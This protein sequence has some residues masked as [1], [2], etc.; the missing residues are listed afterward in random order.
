MLRR[1]LLTAAAA[2][3]LIIAT[4]IAG[5]VWYDAILALVLFSAVVE[6]LLAAGEQ[7]RDP[8][9]WLAAVAAGGF[10]LSAR[11]GLQWPAALLAGF[12]LVSLTWLVLSERLD[13]GAR[14]WLLSTG[15]AVYVGWLGLHFSLLRH[16]PHGQSWA[17]LAIF[18]TFAYDSG[19]Y[20]FGRLFGRRLLAP[21]I[22]PKKTLEGTAG[23]LVC[24]ALAAP[25]LNRLLGP[26]EPLPWMVVLGA[27]LGAVA[28]LG[29]LA[30]SL[31]KRRLE[32]K[33]AGLLAPGHG[34][35]LDRLDSL[36]FVGT[37][38]YYLVRWFSA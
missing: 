13:H 18:T 38:L 31:L 6:F 3:P 12:L 19:A 22:S 26:A 17:F 36:L 15:I 32:M 25:L 7:A 9:L 23:G 28:Q 14:S 1:R 4:V 2:I 8:L 10:A 5:G 11:W 35:L 33:D 29:D 27:G 30:E 37:V 21:R 16:L 20:A 34:G 24:A